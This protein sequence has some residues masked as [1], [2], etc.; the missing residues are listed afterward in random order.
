MLLSQ[1]WYGE[2][3][4]LR[5][6]GSAFIIGADFYENSGYIRAYHEQKH[7]KHIS[8][9][10]AMEKQGLVQKV[11]SFEEIKGREKI[12]YEITESLKLLRVYK[13]NLTKVLNE[14]EHAYYYLTVSFGVETYVRIKSKFLF[15][16]KPTER[17]FKLVLEKDIITSS[18]YN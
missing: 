16:R 4:K 14:K 6:N 13:D 7:W 15:S 2:N 3:S 11:K 17:G 9:I 8:G 12:P 5:C 1:D 10:S 18:N